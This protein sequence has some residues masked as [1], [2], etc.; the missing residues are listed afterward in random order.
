MATQLEK[1][2]YVIFALQTSRKN[3]ISENISRFNDCKLTNAKLYLNSECYPYDDLNLD[4]D[5]NR[6]DSVRSYMRVSAT[7]DTSISSRVSLLQ[8]FYVMARS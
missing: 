2:R 1:L 8:L 6:C 3:V 7:T 4:F 5:K